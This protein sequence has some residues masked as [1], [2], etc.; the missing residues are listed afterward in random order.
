MN[1]PANR[2]APYVA[3]W[4][5]AVSAPGGNDQ[6]WLGVW[7]LGAAIVVK[8]LI[9]MFSPLPRSLSFGL[10]V[11]FPLAVYA[12]IMWLRFLR[13]AILQN[14]PANGMLVPGLIKRLRHTAIVVYAAGVACWMII[15]SVVPRGDTLMMFVCLAMTFAMLA[16]ARPFVFYLG[17]ILIWLGSMAE[18]LFGLPDLGSAQAAHGL[19][20][21][22]TAL[23]TWWAFRVAFSAGSQTASRHNTGIRIVNALVQ[24]AGKAFGVD[25]T[26]A[27][28]AYA[29]L[30]RRDIAAGKAGDLMLHALG[31][32]NHRYDY[33]WALP[34]F[35]VFGI[36]PKLV[37]D[38]LWPGH[39]PLVVEISGLVSIGAFAVLALAC[40][41]RFNVSLPATGAE[42]GLF[43]L[44]P[45]AP[46]APGLNRLLAGKLLRICLA[47]WAACTVLMLMVSSVWSLPV[48]FVALLSVHML[49]LLSAAGWPLRDYAHARNPRRWEGIAQGLLMLALGVVTLLLFK[50]IGPLALALPIAVSAGLILRRWR[51]MVAAP[52][53]FPAG[54]M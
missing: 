41:Y 26:V 9:L 1:A 48:I 13:G 4:R 37:S 45:M 51:I 38:L 30:L 8:C 11:G 5:T 28:R 16:F 47:E 43:R 12:S 20:Y 32:R 50:I 7:F 24:P 21:L 31:P 27:G 2:L 39:T 42:Q 53:A 35:A 3:V 40:P 23:L 54:R 10:A 6:P 49:S 25:R 22:L 46:A 19:A 33:L 44:T 36:V 18:K 29:R 17:M 15:A 52:V 34:L 14:T